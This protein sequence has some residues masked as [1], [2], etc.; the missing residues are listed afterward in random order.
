MIPV[1]KTG[2]APTIKRLSVKAWMKGTTSAFSDGRTPTDGLV[3]SGNVML[4]QDGTIRQRPSLIKYGTQPLGTILGKMFE[5]VDTS[6]ATPENNIITMQKTA[7]NEVQTLTITGAP[8]GGHFTLTYAGQTTGNIAYNAVAAD[9]QTALIALSNLAPGDVV[10]TGGALPSTAVTITFGGTLANTDVALITKTDSF[11][12]GSAPASHIVEAQKGGNR[13]L[14]YWNQD[15][16]DWTLDAATVPVGFDAAAETRYCQIDEKVLIMNQTDA[17]AY[18]DIPTKAVTQFVALANPSAPSLAQTGMVGTT[19][20]YYY[21]ITA[22]STVGE[23]AA[24]AEASQQVA[25]LRETWDASHYIDV[26]WSAVA[27]AKS[28]NVY[29]ATVSGDEVLLAQGV[30]GLTFRD[31]GTIAK[32]VAI[33]AP[34]FNS[35][36]GPKV[37]RGSVINGQVFLVGDADDP[38]LIRFGGVGDFILDFS[39]ANGGGSTRI[40]RGGKELPVVVESFRTGKGDAAITVLCKG[41]NGTG[42]RYIL[43]PD[44]ITSGTTVI[45]FFDVNEDNGQT[46]T[47]SPD[48]VVLYRDQLL[49][50]STDGFKTT[51]TK[52]QLQ[53]VLSTDTISETIITDIFKLNTEFMEKCV[54]IARQDKVYWALPVG[55]SSNNQIWVLDLARGGAWMEPWTVAADDMIL[56]NDNSGLTH[57]L[58]LSNNTIYEFSDAQATNDDGVPFSTNA[59]SGIFKFSPDSLEWAK[60]IDVTFILIDAEGTITFSVSGKTED[61]PLSALGDTAF[62]Q[63]SSVAGWGEAGWGG[64]PDTDQP[65]IYGWSDFNEVPETFGDAQELIVVEVDEELEW[66]SW[67]INSVG[68]G[69]RYQIADVVV[70]YVDIGVKDLT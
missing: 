12:G 26:T 8:T 47:D 1:P 45:S 38:Y 55:T 44:T 32:Q 43:T 62:T 23:T 68:A 17:L 61:E 60:V 52:P 59:T 21:K 63:Q 57:H 67:E 11:T 56:Y 20:T 69:V 36:G 29:I 6:T 14:I 58:V 34:A 31:D 7:T 48:G 51:G 40:G 70:R 9:V 19:Y 33:A 10:C 30:V 35:T 46:G 37:K 50:P 49:Y 53:N 3:R 16:G 13:G 41:T 39:P 24:S 64:S 22:N 2:P 54:G 42:K 27:G 25:Q 18:F 28:Y 15:G 65:K 5:F 66:I 4:D